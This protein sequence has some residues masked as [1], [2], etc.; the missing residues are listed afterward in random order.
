MPAPVIT[1]SFFRIIVSLGFIVG[2]LGD[3]IDFLKKLI[4]PSDLL[5]YVVSHPVGCKISPLALLG[6]VLGGVIL[7]LTIF[8]GLLLFWRPAR[9]LT[10]FSC[11][12]DVIIASLI[13]PTIEPGGVIALDYLSMLLTGII[14][15]LIYFSPIKEYFVKNEPTSQP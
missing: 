12:L 9:T 14:I 1:K 5:N 13:N 3:T 7:D 4:F 2:I 15:G 11:I 6:I 8:I 10:L